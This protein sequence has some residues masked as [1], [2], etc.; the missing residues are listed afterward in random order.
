MPLRGPEGAGGPFVIGYVPK[1]VQCIT[2]I[3]QIGRAGGRCPT[4]VGQVELGTDCRAQRFS[5]CNQAAC[6]FRSELRGIWRASGPGLPPAAKGLDGDQVFVVCGGMKPGD[7]QSRPGPA[8]L[9]K[10]AAGG[11]ASQGP[12]VSWAAAPSAVQSAVSQRSLRS[13]SARRGRHRIVRSGRGHSAVIRSTPDRP[14]WRALES[15]CPFPGNVA[16]P[17]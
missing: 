17:T 5:P 4:L 9:W 3:V 12:N 2:I 7:A 15:P 14:R 11:S 1:I 16:W 6:R 10:G 13:R 8:E